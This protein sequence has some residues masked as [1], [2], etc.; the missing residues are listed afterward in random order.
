MVGLR[1][2]L[3]H[4][5]SPAVVPPSSLALGIR[6]QSETN[7]LQ[8]AAR[9]LHPSTSNPQPPNNI[10]QTATR[11]HCTLYHSCVLLNTVRGE[12]HD[13]ILGLL[14]HSTLYVWELWRPLTKV[15]ES[16]LWREML[17]K[18]PGANSDN[19]LL[20]SLSQNGYGQSI[21]VRTIIPKRSGPNLKI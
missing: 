15:L 19:C 14:Q 5:I 2:S 17:E 16:S 20:E 1:R 21:N 7:N 11:I 4:P 10:P 9:N 8:P 6:E 12:L 3:T 18:T 13:D